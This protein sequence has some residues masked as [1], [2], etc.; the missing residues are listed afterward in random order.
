L[1][2]E[3]LDLI[4]AGQHGAALEVDRW[5]D[6]D[7]IVANIRD[8]ER[9]DALGAIKVAGCFDSPHP[10]D[11]GHFREQSV[12]LFDGAAKSSHVIEGPDPPPPGRATRRS[13]ARALPSEK[14]DRGRTSDGPVALRRPRR[15]NAGRR[16]YD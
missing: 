7:R 15:P 11:Q 1:A 8:A 2:D 14:L 13:Q 4:A 16:R 12:P 3:R 6:D 9:T 10:P 5:L